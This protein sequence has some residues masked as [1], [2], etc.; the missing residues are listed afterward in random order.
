MQRVN[1]D[2]HVRPISLSD[3]IRMD[4]HHRCVLI[5]ELYFLHQR[6]ASLLSAIATRETDLPLRELLQDQ[7]VVDQYIAGRLQAV[8]SGHGMRPGPSANLSSTAVLEEVRHADRDRSIAHQRPIALR[9]ALRSLR[10]HAIRSWSELLDALDDD[11][12]SGLRKEI[13]TLQ[14]LEADQYRALSKFGHSDQSGAPW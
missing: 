5:N 4:M 11:H 14:T 10:L 6:T 1:D 12:Q 9:N 3:R 2:H 8:A 7:R 13:L